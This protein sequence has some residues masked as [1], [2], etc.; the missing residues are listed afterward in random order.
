[1]T[2][3]APASV[4]ASTTS[5]STTEIQH[6]YAVSHQDSKQ[7]GLK[8]KVMSVFQSKHHAHSNDLEPPHQQDHNDT[9]HPDIA[10][11]SAPIK[12]SPFPPDV[13]AHNPKE[14]AAPAAEKPYVL[15]ESPEH[16]AKIPEFP[17]GADVSNA[18]RRNNRQ[19]APAPLPD[20]H[21]ISTQIPLPNTGHLE[22]TENPTTTIEPDQNDDSVLVVV[23]THYVFIFANPRSGNQQGDPLVKLNIQHYRLRDRPHVQVQIYNFLSDKERSAGLKYLRLLLRKPWDIKVVH[24][25]SAGGDGTLMG[26]VEGMISTGIDVNDPRILFSVVPFGTG[27]DLSQVLGWGRFVSGK[28][29]AGHH[30]DGLNSMVTDRLEGHPARLDVWEVVIETHENGWIREAGKDTKIDSLKRK[31][32]NYSSIGIQGRVGAGFEANRRGSRVLNAMEYTRQSLDI[33]VHGVTRVNR[34]IKSIDVQQENGEREVFEMNRRRDLRVRKAPVELVI[35][36]IPGMW[37]RQVDLWGTAKM[38]P[39]ILKKETGPTD[40]NNWTPNTAYD[41]KL[42]VFGISS[43]RSYLAKQLP[44]GRHSL[45]RV[46]QFPTGTEIVFKEGEHIHAMVDGEFYEITS[47]KVM[48]FTRVMQI[49]LVGPKLSDRESRLVRDEVERRAEMPGPTGEGHRAGVDFEVAPPEEAL[50]PGDDAQSL[51][52]TDTMESAQV[53]GANGNGSANDDNEMV[54]E[55]GVRT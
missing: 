43:L 7:Q 47:P 25:W 50:K 23:P 19:F 31:M 10:K 22:I 54:G 15:P 12:N 27:N 38:S 2:S 6:P 49:R 17:A 18:Q 32:S 14:E 36:N 42:E 5:S 21:A 24:V 48:R 46:G 52:S 8:S 35:Q 30:L 9:T 44:W 37:G 40:I 45:Q 41:G 11:L 51:S 53:E 33:V 1:M 29:V 34:S 13:T 16:I 39:S 3:V 28:D 55:S 26:V 4:T 20:Q